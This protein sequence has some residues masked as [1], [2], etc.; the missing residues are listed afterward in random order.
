M[1]MVNPQGCFCFHMKVLVIELARRSVQH[2]VNQK[3]KL[4]TYQ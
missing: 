3:S 1:V 4:E 2:S